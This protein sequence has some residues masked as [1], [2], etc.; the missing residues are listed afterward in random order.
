MPLLTTP[1][2]YPAYGILFSVK[3]Y[4]GK[5]MESNHYKDGYVPYL[6]ANEDDRRGERG[7]EKGQGRGGER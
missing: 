4:I 2:Y 5:K 7:R 3:G 6:K 1:L